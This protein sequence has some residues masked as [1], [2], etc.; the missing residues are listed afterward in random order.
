MLIPNY[1]RFD[2]FQNAP[3][4]IFC[5]SCIPADAEWLRCPSVSLVQ[6]AR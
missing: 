5:Y 6:L 3:A 4:I 2:F 1:K